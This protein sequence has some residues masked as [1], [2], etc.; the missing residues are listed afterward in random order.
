MMLFLNLLLWAYSLALQDSYVAPFIYMFVQMM[1]QG[2]REL[3]TS[4]S[5]PF[6]VDEVDFEM[7]DWMNLAYSKMYSILVCKGEAEFPES[8]TAKTYP[9]Q[10]PKRASCVIDV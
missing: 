3:A 1:F 5:N 8:A 10:K 2:I 7:N 4:L 6:G 9:M